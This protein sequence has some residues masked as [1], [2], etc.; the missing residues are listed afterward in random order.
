[1]YTLPSC[2][3]ISDLLFPA[4]S[5]FNIPYHFKYQMNMFKYNH[6]LTKTKQQQSIEFMG[7]R[8]LASYPVFRPIVITWEI[9]LRDL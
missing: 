6:P 9:L 4:I 3:K 2:L 5:R 8:Y 1:M 7:C